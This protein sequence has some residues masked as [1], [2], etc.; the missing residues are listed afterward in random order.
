MRAFWDTAEMLD[1]TIFGALD[2]VDQLLR[3]KPLRERTADQ[4]K[5]VREPQR[6]IT[7]EK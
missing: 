4:V 1:R 6:V 7:F 2:R 5:D 3:K